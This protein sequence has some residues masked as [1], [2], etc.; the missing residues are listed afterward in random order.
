MDTSNAN[1]TIV[2]PTSVYYV[3]DNS[4]SNDVYT[5]AVGSDSNDGLTPATPMANLQ[6]L[7]NLRDLGPGDTV[8][9]DTGT[10]NLASD[11]QVLNNDSGVTIVGVPSTVTSKTIFNRG[12]VTGSNAF[13]LNNADNVTLRNFEVT[14]AGSV[15]IVIS[16]DSDDV[17]I[18][19]SRLYGSNIQVSGDATSDRTR[20]AQSIFGGQSTRR[21]HFV[22][23]GNNALI[24]FNNFSRGGGGGGGSTSMTLSGAASIFRNNE[25]VDDG[26][27]SP[28]RPF[29]T[30][31]DRIVVR[32]NLFRDSQA[33]ALSSFNGELIESNTFRNLRNP[34]A[35]NPPIAITSSAIVRNNLIYDTDIGFSGGGL[36]E[37]NRIFNNDV[38]VQT[39]TNARIVGN[40]IYD[41]ALGIRSFGN[42]DQIVNNVLL[43]NDTGIQFTTG[44]LVT[45]SNNTILQPVGNAIEFNSGTNGQFV[46]NIF[47]VENGIVFNAPSGA[48]ITGSDY[49]H[50]HLAQNARI[51]NLNGQIIG[52]PNS[53]YYAFGYDK[54]SSSGDPQFVDLDGPDD[55]LG[56]D[57]G[58]GILASYFNNTDFSGSPVLQRVEPR[59][60]FGLFGQSGSPAAGVNPDNFTV[61]WEGFVHIATPGD[62]TFFVQNNDGVRFYF[63]NALRIDQWVSN[64]TE[65]SYVASALSS[66]WYP[67]R[68]EMREL[69]GT[70]SAR[71]HWQGQELPSRSFPATPWELSPAL[72]TQIWGR[73][74]TLLFSP[75]RPPSMQV[76]QCLYF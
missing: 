14:G 61:R 17:S 50:F 2:A 64:S 20:I 40:Q 74:T 11:V 3:N 13:V 27:F 69:T 52:D 62:Y 45:V 31:A 25:S 28:S 71:M 33:S 18:L 38:G 6:A 36:F 15:G 54:N 37:N 57:R 60:D 10:Y 12:G 73:T 26:T 41:N 34:G 42:N 58:N 72:R 7:L 67:I 1:L 55:K 22:L 32:D 63:D 43:R 8:F 44:S 5:T 19:D 66:G 70:A 21:Q 53:W 51:A 75:R 23:A 24:E 56:F 29:T 65:Y 4:T 49:N 48:T 68:Y 39:G 16:N 46:N 76:I 9:V 35:P 30:E 47:S 59:V